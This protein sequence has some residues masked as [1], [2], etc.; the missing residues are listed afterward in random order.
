MNKIFNP[1]FPHHASQLNTT[2]NHVNAAAQTLVANAV[3]ALTPQQRQNIEL[4]YQNLVS[5]IDQALHASFYTQNQFY[6]FLNNNHHNYFDRNNPEGHITSSAFVVN[7]ERDSMLLVYHKKLDK[8]L[9]AGGHWEEVADLPIT[10][11]RNALKELSEEAFNNA[12]VAYQALYGE[13][14]FHLDIHGVGTHTHFD[15]GYLLEIDPA[16]HP[17]TC[18]H[19]SLDVKWFRFDYILSQ[20]HTREFGS[21]RLHEVIYQ[22]Q[23]APELKVFTPLLTP[24]AQE[25]MVSLN[26][27][28]LNNV[29]NVNNVK[30]ITKHHV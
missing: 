17:L 8:W 26:T 14:A 10:L 27:D 15:V 3:K 9:Q 23:N 18:S 30:K 22:I 1:Q 19:E 29:D 5:T 7:P 16:Q 20:R 12:V 2:V 4:G 28:P 13:K 11:F 6:R 24:D 21:E 25:P